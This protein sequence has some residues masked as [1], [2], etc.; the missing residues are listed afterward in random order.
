[1][2]VLLL[3]LEACMGC[4]AIDAWKAGAVQGAAAL[5]SAMQAK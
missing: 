1:V 2:A 5:G 4:F 3:G